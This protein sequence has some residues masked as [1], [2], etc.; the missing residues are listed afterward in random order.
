MIEYLKSLE[1]IKSI[2]SVELTGLIG[3]IESNQVSK[4]FTPCAFFRHY[5]SSIYIEGPMTKLSIFYLVLGEQ[6]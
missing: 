1:L 3:L 6:K 4:N 5:F 2:E